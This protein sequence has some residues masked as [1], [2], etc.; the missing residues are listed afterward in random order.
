MLRRP[1]RA[2]PER[3]GQG[4][5]TFALELPP[6]RLALDVGHGEPELAVGIAGVVDRQDMRMLQPGRRADLAKEPLAA[7]ALRERGEQDLEGDGEI[8]GEVD[9]GHAP[10]PELPLKRVSLP[11]RLCK[12]SRGSGVVM[13]RSGRLIRRGSRSQAMRDGRGGPRLD[14]IRDRNECPVHRRR[15]RIWGL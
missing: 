11:Q 4:K 12:R 10:A 8:V 5:L 3:V 9:D 14:G 15:F 6:E 13:M 7:E 2:R 1:P